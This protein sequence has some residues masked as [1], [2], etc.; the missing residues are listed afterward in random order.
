MPE[1]PADRPTEPLRPREPVAAGVAVER[2]VADPGWVARLDDQLRSLKTM[3]ALIGVLS[4][5][6][7]GAALYALLGDEED[8]DSTGASRDRVA[9]IDERVDRLESKAGEASEESDVAGL[10]KELS[11]KADQGDVEQLSADIEELRA[12]VE[13][14]GTD[15][16]VTQELDSLRQGLEALAAE[17]EELRAEQQQAP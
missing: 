16:A 6:A 17:V 2:E 13:E 11:G 12:A 8:V 10:E 7:L 1:H 15:E 9:Q 4:L 5:L 14:G 3:V